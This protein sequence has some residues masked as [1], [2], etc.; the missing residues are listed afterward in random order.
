M[1]STKKAVAY[2]RVSTEGQEDKFGLEAQRQQIQDYADENGY[3]IV[4]WHEEVGSGAKERPILESIVEGTVVANPPIE[5]VLVYKN[6]RV[7][8]DMKLYFYYL[9]K[10]E[11]KNIRLIAVKEDFGNYDP[12]IVS[13]L[14][15]M[16]QFVAEQERTN[17]TRRT[18]A[19]R[20]VKAQVGGYCG[21]KTPYGYKS[22][23]K[24]LIVDEYEAEVVR[25]IFDCKSRGMSDALIVN[26]LT[27]LGFKTRAGSLFQSSNIISIRKHEKLYRGYYK[28]SDTEWVKG[29]HEPILPEEEV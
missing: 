27:E 16:F 12:S 14:R 22:E 28:Y 24:E 11:Q 29:R 19:G 10:L 23:N 6:D 20:K 25:T 1:A 3:D 8:R 21:G 17:I 15:A 2:L 9:F 5:A 7:A 4:S 26:R 18:L 13:L